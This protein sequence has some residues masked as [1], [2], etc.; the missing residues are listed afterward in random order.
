[1]NREGGFFGE[2]YREYLRWRE[3]RLF[4]FSK[5]NYGE[6]SEIRRLAEETV[7]AGA[8]GRWGRRNIETLSVLANISLRNRL[9]EEEWRE[10]FERLRR[11]GLIS[12][13]N[14]LM[15]KGVRLV[16]TLKKAGLLEKLAGQVRP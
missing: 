13:N 1:M 8:F 7:G 9:D 10:E 15:P 4:P 5:L 16:K 14:K 3:R 6:F 12:K 2:G 11:L